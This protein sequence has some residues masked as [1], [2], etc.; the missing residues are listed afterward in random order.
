MSA[1][2]AH[3]NEAAGCSWPEQT[4][5][6]PHPSQLPAACKWCPAPNF[7]PYGM[8]ILFFACRLHVAKQTQR[9]L[10]SHPSVRASFT[11]W[12]PSCCCMHTAMFLR[13]NEC[14]LHAACALQPTAAILQHVTGPPCRH[15]A[16]AVRLFCAHYRETHQGPQ[17]WPWQCPIGHRLE[18]CAHYECLEDATAIFRTG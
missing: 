12:L 15:R 17:G 13:S 2:F 7:A 11:H 9:P 8:R 5:E 3:M 18:H 14:L 16:Q 4:A 1:P 10:R 6:M